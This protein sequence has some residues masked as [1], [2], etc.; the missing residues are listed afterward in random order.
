MRGLWK[1]LALI[2]IIV[3]FIEPIYS[4][5][6][7]AVQQ[8][9][10]LAD[11]EEMATMI[12]TTKEKIA[13]IT[14]A[15]SENT[16]IETATPP[17]SE[18]AIA[19]LTVSNTPVTAPVAKIT[20]SNEKELADAMYAYFSSFSPTFEIHYKGSTKR[21]EQ[22]VEEAYE[23]AI[24]RDG[25]VYGHISE[26]AIRYEYSKIAATIYGEQSYLMTPEQATYVEM[27]VQDILASIANSFDVRC[28]ESEGSKRLY[29]V[30][31]SLYK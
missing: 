17:E 1:R 27:N 16:S 12:T 23:D 9:S 15:F 19:Q 30:T 8:I 5:G 11:R 22:M 21:I 31:D 20:V 25:Y 3:I 10:D 14:A 2:L 24:K 26:H 28:R 6:Q 29:C 18:D 4:F 7:M 13:N